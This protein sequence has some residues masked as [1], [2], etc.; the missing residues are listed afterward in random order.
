M[1]SRKPNGKEKEDATV[2]SD[3]TNTSSKTIGSS[4]KNTESQET[5]TSVKENVTKSKDCKTP[6]GPRSRKPPNKGTPGL[7]PDQIRALQKRKI[8]KGEESLLSSFIKKSSK[9]ITD[10][11]ILWQIVID[12]ASERYRKQRE[13][14]EMDEHSK[15]LGKYLEKTYYI[16]SADSCTR[17]LQKKAE[18]KKNFSYDMILLK[19][20]AISQ[21][22]DL[23]LQMPD[24]KTKFISCSNTIQTTPGNPDSPPII[25]QYDPTFGITTSTDD[26]VEET[27]MK[28]PNEEPSVTSQPSQT[29]QSN[30]ENTSSKT[31]QSQNTTDST[32][33][34]TS[35]SNT[36]S[37]PSKTSQGS[38]EYTPSKFKN[39]EGNFVMKKTNLKRSIFRIVCEAEDNPDR[40]KKDCV[41]SIR[42]AVDRYRD[43]KNS[44]S[45]DYLSVYL[46]TELKRRFDN[47]D[48]A[49]AAQAYFCEKFIDFDFG[50]MANLEHCDL[51]LIKS[52]AIFTKRDIHVYMENR[53]EEFFNCMKN[54]L[55]HNKGSALPTIHI[56]IDFEKDEVIEMVG[57]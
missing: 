47:N 12:A 41:Q 57:T 42:V 16:A 38:T 39:L 46:S 40:E 33:S 19:T 55:S 18:H 14:D 8:Q 32:P 9:T 25:L 56:K 1:F 3:K 52:L 36:D 29:S 45:M 43:Q 28:K 4:D 54:N 27:S 50:S 26:A 51:I 30:S 44:N 6:A 49:S 7:L 35:T 37:T 53:V 20:L 2:K 22:C 15:L 17:Y 5:I 13:A 23:L 48:S 34:K 10:E 11:G 31:S 24:K 21:N